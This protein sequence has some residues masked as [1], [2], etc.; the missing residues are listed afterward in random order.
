LTVANAA[1]PGRWEP[2]GVMIDGDVGFVQ[3]S[4]CGAG[5]ES[6]FHL[7]PDSQCRQVPGCGTIGYAPR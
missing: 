7:R 5:G 4:D 3:T 6:D 2:V 1:G